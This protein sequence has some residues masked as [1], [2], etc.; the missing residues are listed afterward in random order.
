MSVG[1]A[2][3]MKRQIRII[4]IMV[5]GVAS[6]ALYGLLFHRAIRFSLDKQVVKAGETFTLIS[7]FYN[8]WRDY[9]R[10]G[11]QV[12]IVDEKGTSRFISEGDLREASTDGEVPDFTIGLCR[13]CRLDLLS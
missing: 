8:T 3:S 1:V 2:S 6:L 7:H 4:S 12:S 10:P 13:T 9:V 11:G 5:A